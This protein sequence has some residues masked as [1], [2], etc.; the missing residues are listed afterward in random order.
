V[1]PPH[2]LGR[3]LPLAGPSVS[4][5]MRQERVTLP[6]RHPASVPTVIG[7]MGY[8]AVAMVAGESPARHPVE[9]YEIAAAFLA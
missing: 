2:H 5:P 1:R 3:A 8:F 7:R 4:F 6:W 9:A